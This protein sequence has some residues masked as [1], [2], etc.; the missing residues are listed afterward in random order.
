MEEQLGGLSLASGV[1]PRE[2][3]ELDA[4]IDAIKVWSCR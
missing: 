4:T 2:A 3:A 1:V